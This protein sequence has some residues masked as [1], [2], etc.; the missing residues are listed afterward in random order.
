MGRE[1]REECGTPSAKNEKS[2][3]WF[4]CGIMHNARLLWC[5]H[6]ISFVLSRTPPFVTMLA[7]DFAHGFVT[8]LRENSVKTLRRFHC[9]NQKGWCCTHRVCALSRG[10]AISFA[11]DL[12]KRLRKKQR[13]Q[14]CETPLYKNNRENAPADLS[15]SLD[16]AKLSLHLH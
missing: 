15:V 10:F 7:L 3:R 8:V 13:I 1:R 5:T 4:R 12:P 16:A 9:S 14:Q 6:R 11:R 2:S